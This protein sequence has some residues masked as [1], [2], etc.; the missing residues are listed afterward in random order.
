MIKKPPSFG[1]WSWRSFGEELFYPVLMLESRYSPPF[2]LYARQIFIIPHFILVV[3]TSTQN[4]KGFYAP[5]AITTFLFLFS[6]VARLGY[7]KRLFKP[8]I[9]YNLNS[10]NC[11]IRISFSNGFYEVFRVFY[12]WFSS[13]FSIF[14]FLRNW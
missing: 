12:Y 2:L 11:F 14:S 4:S 1:A 7:K 3:V 10:S 5:L 8:P 9:N 6:M 13:K